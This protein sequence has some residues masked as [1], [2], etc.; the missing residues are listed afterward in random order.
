VF[1][2][3]ALHE[4][5]VP[6]GRIAELMSAAPARLFG[7]APRKGAIRIGA[8]ADLTIIECNGRRVL[9]ANDLEYHDQERWSPFHGTELRVFPV[10][11]VLRGRVVFAEGEVLGAPGNGDFLGDRSPQGVDDV[12]DLARESARR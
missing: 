1:A 9:D 11:T 5:D 6:L 7:L 8:D 2:T 4:R 12:A 3:Q 10:Y